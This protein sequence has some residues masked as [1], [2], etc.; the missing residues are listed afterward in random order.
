MP[1]QPLVAFHSNVKLVREKHALKML[2]TNLISEIKYIRWL[3]SKNLN[4]FFKLKKNNNEGKIVGIC[5]LS[6]VLKVVFKK[7]PF[8]KDSTVYLISH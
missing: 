5:F 7:L 2:K 1:H 4:L 3:E 6:F 8:P